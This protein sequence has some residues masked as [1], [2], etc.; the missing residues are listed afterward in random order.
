M[1]VFDAGLSIFPLCS[2]DIFPSLPPPPSP[3]PPPPPP[4]HFFRALFLLFLCFFNF[5][6]SFFLLSL[7]LSLFCFVCMCVCFMDLGISSVSISLSLDTCLCRKKDTFLYYCLASFCVRNACQNSGETVTYCLA[8]SLAGLL[9]CFVA[10][11]YLFSVRVPFPQIS[12]S[13]P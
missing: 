5:S 1:F 3:P 9:A 12:L 13:S 10:A 2:L 11:N 8:P 4:P 6:V 7:S